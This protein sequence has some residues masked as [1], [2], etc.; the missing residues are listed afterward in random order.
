MEE[1]NKCSR[2]EQRVEE[3]KKPAE[4]TQSSGKKH[5]KLVPQEPLYQTYLKIVVI[6]RNRSKLVPQ[7]LLYQTYLK[8][9]W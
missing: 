1:K 6:G 7:E 8:H 3:E 5:F 9:E 4:G 2:R